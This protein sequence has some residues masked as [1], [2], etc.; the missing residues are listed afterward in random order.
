M[1]AWNSPHASPIGRLLENQP[2]VQ[3]HEWM[4]AAAN[5]HYELSDWTRAIIGGG[6]GPF[7]SGPRE[8]AGLS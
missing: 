7:T 3:C 8:P 5:I 4:M 1:S 6:I 2:G